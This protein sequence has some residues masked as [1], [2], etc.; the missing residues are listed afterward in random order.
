MHVTQIW[1]RLGLG[2]LVCGA[3]VVGQFLR[4]SIGDDFIS[5][6]AITGDFQFPSYGGWRFGGNLMRRHPC[7]GSTTPKII[8]VCPPETSW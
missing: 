1:G 8:G 5:V 6:V 3:K 4:A 7:H 2:F